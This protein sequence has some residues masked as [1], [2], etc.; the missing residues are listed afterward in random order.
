M[1]TISNSL[2]RC[3]APNS[4]KPLEKPLYPTMEPSPFSSTSKPYSSVSVLHLAWISDTEAIDRA[5]HLKGAW[6]DYGYDV[7]MAS[8]QNTFLST[9]AK[10][11]LLA[12]NSRLRTSS[13]QLESGEIIHPS[14]NATVL[15]TLLFSAETA[16]VRFSV[17]P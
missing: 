13:R 15:S 17:V 11:T 4:S 1:F 2:T 8:E 5:T 14:R 7:T 10:G 16:F 12:I 9:V 6:E 3:L